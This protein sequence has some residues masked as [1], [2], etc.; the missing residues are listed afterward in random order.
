MRESRLRIS[1]KETFSVGR[2]NEHLK[3]VDKSSHNLHPYA[4]LA[5]RQS[6]NTELARWKE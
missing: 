5:C 6:Q 1:E 2:S 4:E 3:M